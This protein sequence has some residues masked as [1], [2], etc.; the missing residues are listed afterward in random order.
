MQ[1]KVADL[2]GQ[3]EAPHRLRQPLAQ[4]DQ[5]LPRL[6]PAKGSRPPCCWVE[7]LHVQ[8]QPFR[9]LIYRRLGR[10]IHDELE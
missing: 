2:V 10:L 8:T 4:K 1:Q 7:S 6:E 3:G 9:E 5:I